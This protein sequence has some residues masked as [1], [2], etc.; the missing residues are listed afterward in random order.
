MFVSLFCTAW[1][2]GPWLGGWLQQVS[3]KQSKTRAEKVTQ[4]GHARQRRARRRACIPRPLPAV[5]AI[6]PRS[7]RQLL[8]R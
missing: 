2:S 8:E 1:L 7:D 4:Q 3:A 6:E 5:A